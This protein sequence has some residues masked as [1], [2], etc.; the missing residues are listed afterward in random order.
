MI[1]GP[2]VSTVVYIVIVFLA[3]LLGYAGGFN[4]GQKVSKEQ[5]IA[6]MIE[7][8]W[9]KYTAHPQTSEQRLIPTRKFGK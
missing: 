8:G 9:V 4:E 2:K 6:K 1:K 5:V 7:M 3:L